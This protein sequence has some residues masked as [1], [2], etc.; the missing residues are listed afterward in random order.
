MWNRKRIS[1]VH[2]FFKRSKMNLKHKSNGVTWMPV[3]LSYKDNY[4]IITTFLVDGI[5]I[6]MWYRKKIKLVIT[7]IH[8]ARSEFKCSKEKQTMEIRRKIACCRCHLKNFNKN[9]REPIEYHYMNRHGIRIKFS[10]EGYF[11]NTPHY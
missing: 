10:M 11:V 8:R 9:F 5:R 6:N 7:W 2:T 1:H 4:G 3:T